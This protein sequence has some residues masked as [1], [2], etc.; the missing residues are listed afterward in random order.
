MVRH[1]LSA[2]REASSNKK[3]Q[4][5]PFPINEIHEY[6]TDIPAATHSIS[7]TTSAKME[8]IVTRE[9]LAKLDSSWMVDTLNSSFPGIDYKSV[10]VCSSREAGG[11]LC[12]IHR[13]AFLISS[14]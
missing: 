2:P 11:A 5:S 7:R 10:N 9:T 3:A 4:R 12:D 1:A 6:Q 14:A 8:Q 13:L